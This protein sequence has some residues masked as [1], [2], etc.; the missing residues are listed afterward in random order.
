MRWPTGGWQKRKTTYENAA[1]RFDV[2]EAI[3]TNRGTNNAALRPFA[4][5]FKEAGTS[6]DAAN[7]AGRNRDAKI[8]AESLQKFEKVFAE[9]LSKVDADKKNLYE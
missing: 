1:Y 6:L 5:Q 2:L 7:D 9:L 8:F 4:A 3:I